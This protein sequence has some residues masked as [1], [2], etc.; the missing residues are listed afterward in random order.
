M[1][2]CEKLGQVHVMMF[3][4]GE[5]LGLMRFAAAEQQPTTPHLLPTLLRWSSSRAPHTL[6]N[7]NLIF[8]IL[9]LLRAYLLNTNFK[10]DCHVCLYRWRRQW[11]ADFSCHSFLLEKLGRVMT[12]EAFLMLLTKYQN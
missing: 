4:L 5:N 8:F 12:A 10:G 9:K 7:T 3:V 6:K 11:Q 1:F 2:A